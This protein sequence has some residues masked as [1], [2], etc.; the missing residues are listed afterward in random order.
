MTWTWLSRFEASLPPVSGVANAWMPW[1]LLFAVFRNDLAVDN[2]QE[3]DAFHKEAQFGTDGYGDIH[4]SAFAE[5]IRRFFGE[6]LLGRLVI[7]TRHV[8][9][10]VGCL[11]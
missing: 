1:G 9:V 3:G 10:F 7:H 2:A 8:A 4:R 11:L 5:S 6:Q